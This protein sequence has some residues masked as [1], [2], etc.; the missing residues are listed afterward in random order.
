MKTK[1]DPVLIAIFSALGLN[2]ACSKDIGDELPVEISHGG[3]TSYEG[4]TG[5]DGGTD[6]TEETDET[7][8]TNS[9]G[10]DET[11][12]PLPEPFECLNP[13]SINQAGSFS[14]SGWVR[15]DGGFVHRQEALE[16]EVP[17]ST[18]DVCGSSCDCSA[19]AYGTCTQTFD[20]SC[21]CTPGCKT[22]ADCSPGSIC[23]CGGVLSTT[24]VTR[25]VPSN[26]TTSSD[27]GPGLCGISEFGDNCGFYYNAGCAG[28]DDECHIDSDCSVEDCPNPFGTA[29]QYECM[30]SDAG[31]VCAPPDVCNGICG[32]PF[33]VEG[34]ARVAPTRAREDWRT[35]CSPAPV[36]EH[37]RVR[38]VEYWT[39]I[40]QFEHAS[41]ASF[42]RF[43]LHLARLG[44]PPQ[45]L[46]ATQCAVVDEV[47]HAQLAFGLASGYAGAPIGP[48][49]LDMRSSL[50]ATDVFEIVEGLI[51]EACIGETLASLEAREA[52][53]HAQDPVVAAVLDEI[54]ADELRHAQLGWRTLAWILARADADLHA[55]VMTRFDEAV[56]ELA[57][58]SQAQ[59]LP[60]SLR[61]HGVVDDDLRAQVQRVGIDELIRPCIDALRERS[62]APSIQRELTALA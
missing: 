2:L 26:C 4:T 3:T 59:G 62:I 51:R 5:T 60:R 22:D 23:V 25:C 9:D 13:E 14:P 7:D 30:P 58:A 15:C 16:C 61:R 21:E 1:I 43:G 45:L 31:F 38:L 19:Y 35:S 49:P 10:T 28:P 34:E 33:F 52:A 42:A 11:G 20:E 12:D 46:R 55:F 17:E 29:E 39:Q 56:R 24:T 40:G 36:A 50:D 18:D 8:E 48:G 6:E 44:A 41:V 53:A 57:G 32:R 54:A 37:E 47:R 27:C